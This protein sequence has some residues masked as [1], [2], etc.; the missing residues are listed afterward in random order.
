MTLNFAPAVRH[1]AKARVAIIGPTGA[2]TLVFEPAV[3]PLGK[4]ANRKS[5]ARE[6][7]LAKVKVPAG[8]SCWIWQGYVMPTTGYGQCGNNRGVVYVHR[9]A[10]EVFV[11]PIPDGL[12]I[13][14]LCRNRRCIKPSHLEPVTQAENNQ[15]SW[16]A[17]KAG[18]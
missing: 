9:L 2:G 16:D 13:D 12:H 8:S 17:R 15:R 4:P 11:G 3:S 14:H 5:P 18:R 1:E 7:L 10:Y 6:R